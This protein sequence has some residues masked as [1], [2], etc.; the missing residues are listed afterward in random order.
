MRDLRPDSEVMDSKLKR[1]VINELIAE[2][3]KV[4]SIETR[5]DIGLEESTL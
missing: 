5:R 3:C 2:K 4:L 1:L